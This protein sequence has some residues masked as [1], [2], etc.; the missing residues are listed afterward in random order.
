MKKYTD[1]CDNELDSI[2]AQV[3]KENSNCG[4]ELNIIWLSMR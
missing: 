1:I 4:L 3:Q 2:T